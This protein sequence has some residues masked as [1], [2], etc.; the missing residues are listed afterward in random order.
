MKIR[1]SILALVLTAM[2]MFGVTPGAAATGG[3]EP[4]SAKM[5]CDMTIRYNGVAQS[6]RNANFVT[7]YPISY[8]DTTYLPVRT[9]ANLMRLE[10]NWDE[11]T[12]TVWLGSGYVSQPSAEPAEQLI[13]EKIPGLY[14]LDPYDYSKGTE[15][16]VGDKTYVSAGLLMGNFVICQPDERGGRIA[17]NPKTGTTMPVMADP[18]QYDD[19]SGNDDWR[20][21]PVKDIAAVL[22]YDITIKYDGEVQE[23]TDA[24]GNL[25]Y[26]ISYQDA[27]Y[28]PVRAIANMLGLE[29]RW[30]AADNTIW[31][32]EGAD[33]V[34]I[35]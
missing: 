35:D 32:D 16:T 7:I 26:P 22:N 5:I 11:A 14:V 20:D 6:L 23:M 30:D 15:F 10:V 8:Q 25:V 13:S 27:T 24:A 33:Q 17:I 9:I 21:T 28:L 2:V 1:R 19:G 29:V 3:T 34:Q 12:K 18:T 31:L 4:I